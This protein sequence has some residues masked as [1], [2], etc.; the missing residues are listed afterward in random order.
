M[1]HPSAIASGND[2]QDGDREGSD[3]LLASV[4]TRDRLAA[5]SLLDCRV[6]VSLASSRR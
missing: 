2:T 4:H 6:L 1:I 3:T 5:A